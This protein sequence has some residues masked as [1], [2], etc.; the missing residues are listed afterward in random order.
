MLPQTVL[1]KLRSQQQ[2]KLFNEWKRTGCPTPPPHLV[3]QMAIREYQEKYGH[4]ILVETG[5]YMGDM[6]EAQKARFRK[7]FSIELSID[8]FNKA[9]KRFSKDKNV[10]YVQEDSGDYH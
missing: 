8:L 1:T 7:V 6:V 4:Q 2:I 5:T 10:I 9:K 3:K